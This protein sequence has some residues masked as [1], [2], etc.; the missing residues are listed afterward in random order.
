ML[1]AC[2]HQWEDLS[3]ACH[4][5]GWPRSPPATSL[6]ACLP[7]CPPDYRLLVIPRM[8][9]ANNLCRA[10]APGSASQ[11][12]KAEEEE[13]EE[14]LAVVVRGSLGTWW[15]ALITNFVW[16]GRAGGLTLKRAPL[17][18]KCQDYSTRTETGLAQSSI[19]WG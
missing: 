9:P 1:M 7:A 10:P 16:G 15:P 11:N 12:N 8:S 4:D 6:P 17:G 19:D 2:W 5:E 18:A 14:V 13:E 3:S